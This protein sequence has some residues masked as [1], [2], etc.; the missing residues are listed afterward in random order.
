MEKFMFLF[1]GS[2]VY[3]PEQSP[4][5]LQALTQK[6]MQWVGDLVGKGSHVGSEKFT[7]VGN[8][9]SGENKVLTDQP[10]GEAKDIIGGCTIVQARDLSEAIEIAKRCPI[11]E[12]HATIEIRPM[13]SL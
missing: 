9:V 6:M 1:R 8:V 3:Q 12:S 10:Y 5:A 11:L 2:E 13:L 7:R 4:E